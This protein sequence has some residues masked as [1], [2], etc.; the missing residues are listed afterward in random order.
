[1]AAIVVDVRDLIGEATSVFWPDQQV[2]NAINEALIDAEADVRTLIGTA[3]ITATA[4]A[5]FIDIPNTEVLIPQRVVSTNGE[6]WVIRQPQLEQFYAD[7]RASDAVSSP[8]FFSLWD[9]SHLRVWPPAQTTTTFVLEGILWPTEIVGPTDVLLLEHELYHSIMY[10][11]A[12]ILLET[13]QPL[14]AD[15]CN[16]LADSHLS[17]YKILMRKRGGHVLST[18]RPANIHQRAQMGSIYIGKRFQ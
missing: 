12:A 13:T 18:L 7:W 11:A 14:A 16:K 5:K 3:T 2:Y 4:S 10:R 6:V 1:M 17:D 9:S 8:L 15:E